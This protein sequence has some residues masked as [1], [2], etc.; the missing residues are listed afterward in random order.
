[1]NNPEAI[2][3]EGA[4]LL[5]LRD[6]YE[7][8]PAR[9]DSSTYFPETSEYKGIGQFSE[10]WRKRADAPFS[11]MAGTGAALGQSHIFILAGSDG[12]HLREVFER[13][14][15][16][17]KDYDHPG[18]TK[19]SLA[20]HTITDTW[21]EAGSTP[22]NQVTTPAANWED[23]III[24]SGEFCPRVRTAHVWQINPFKRSRAFGS[25]N[26]TVL[27][28]YLLAMVG[29]GVYFANKNKNTDDYPK[30]QLPIDEC[31]KGPIGNTDKRPEVSSH[32]FWQ[33]S[34]DRLDASSLVS[35]DRKEPGRHDQKTENKCDRVH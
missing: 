14:K 20:Y 17:M 5:P 9:Y 11:F 12:S 13:R 25:L 3:A 24:V 29:V 32:P 22:A 4:K 15:I 10:P 1:M 28:V 35:Q 33:H 31:P 2:L 21:V 26:F 18:F 8:C 30:N 23:D 16:A 19:R 27:T 6:V 7:F 34:V